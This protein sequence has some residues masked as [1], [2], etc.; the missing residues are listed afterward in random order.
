MNNTKR[1]S[2]FVAKLG[3]IDA[4]LATLEKVAG[5]AMSGEA[6]GLEFS[7][8]VKRHNPVADGDRSGEE[9]WAQQLLGGPL[10]GHPFPSGSSR[11]A[12]DTTSTAWY[13]I[14]E[15]A[16]TWF[17]ARFA[18]GLRAQRAE[19]LRCLSVLSQEIA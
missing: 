16:A 1:I 14:P 17:V 13:G 5:V 2:D 7:V 3:G 4:Q 15:E 10:W 8:R 11:T 19:V 6:T 12:D 18:E 9:H